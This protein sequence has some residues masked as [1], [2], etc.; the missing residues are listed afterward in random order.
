MS[1]ARLSDRIQRIGA[2]ATMTITQTAR[3]MKAA[4]RDVISLSAGEPDFDTPEHIRRA[5]TDA[6]NAGATRYT[7]VDGIPELKDAIIRKFERDNGLTYTR[8][9]INVSPGG[10]PVIF[11]ALA[12]TIGAGDEV[13]I[14]APCWVSYPDMVR[15]CEATPIVIP[16]GAE[17]EFKLTPDALQAVLNP[18]TKWLML[19]SPSNPTG[20]A[21][22]ADEL[23]ALAGI[24]RAHPQ[25]MILCDD[26]Y[27]HLVYD[28][29]EFA[30]MAQVAPDLFA[31][32]L[33]MNGVSKAYA[34]TGWRIGYA[35]G[36]DWLIKAMAK[37]MGQTTSNPASISQWA[38][39][40]ALNGPQDFLQDWRATYKSRRDHVVK[41]LNAID[42]VSCL[43]PP[44]AFYAFADISAIT[45]D[46]AR[47]ALD[48]L[49]ETGVATVPGS[50]FHAPGHIRISYAA[51]M[52]ELDAA[53][54]RIAGFVR[55]SWALRLRST[56][57]PV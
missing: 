50:A 19:N 17:T 5:A 9:Q 26:I 53:L 38:A 40:A 1:D 10:K 16:C 30:T 6:M 8:A 7:A 49:E 3:K 41:K 45:H 18:K 32:T 54:D 36:P 23:K 43:V 28:E 31:R 42:G 46:D 48:L 51:A 20:A 4:G 29:F 11:N 25:V 22:S 37:Y 24:L 52:E 2:S 47:F 15:L 44:G 33:T 12:V 13:I 57:L 21:Y 39:V 56:A 14:P 34:M 35:G 27:E 55:K